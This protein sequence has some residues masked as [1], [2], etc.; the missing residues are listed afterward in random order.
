MENLKRKIIS[1]ICTGEKMNEDS[2]FRYLNI[3]FDEDKKDVRIVLSD[4]L[5]D[6]ILIEYEDAFHLSESN[7][8]IVGTFKGNDKGF[9]FVERIDRKEDD[10]YVYHM[11]V[12]GA[13]DGDLVHC[14]ITRKKQN[15]K[16]AEVKVLKILEGGRSKY[17]G[18][19]YDN[20]ENGFVQLDNRKIPEPIF[21]SARRRN[22]AQDEDKVFIEIVTR[23]RKAKAPSGEVVEI[24]GN[25]DS[26][27]MD[28]TTIARMKG[29]DIDFAPETLAEADEI[30]ESIQASELVHRKDLRDEMIFTIDGA[31][32]K[33]LDDAVSVKLLANGNYK[34]GVHIADVAH[35]V[36]EGSS[37]DEDALGRATSVYLVDRVIP[38]L[39]TKLSNGVCSL[40]PHVDRL[41]LSCEMEVNREGRVVS[42]EIFESVINSKERLTY[43]DVKKVVLRE[44]DALVSRY[45]HIL[46]I[47]DS[48]KEL[49]L[50]LMRKRELRG[51]IDF[52]FPESKVILDEENHPVDIKKYDR[53]IAT[54]IIEEFMILANET[55]SEH[56]T[57]LEVP[58]VYRIHEEPDAERMTKFKTFIQ[59]FGYSLD[60]EDPTPADLQ[61][62]L[63]QLSGQ[64]EEFAVQQVMLRSLRKALYSPKNAGHFG[65]A[66]EYYSHFTSPIRR[67]PDLQI[68][69]IIKEQLRGK[70]SE[71][72]I[73]ELA[74]IVTTSSNHSSKQELLAQEAERE[75]VLLK[76][77]EYMSKYIGE[78]FEGTVSG[79]TEYGVYVQL[80]NTVEGLIHVSNLKDDYYSYDELTFSLVGERTARRFSLGDKVTVK[81]QHVNVPKREIDFVPVSVE[82][83][84]EEEDPVL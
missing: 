13:L 38:M 36:T 64:N 82:S 43:D 63:T 60:S 23:S 83:T 56:F 11:N 48:A 49:A 59:L 25:K 75:S 22:G 42:H 31:D 71:R 34:L 33:D 69:R 21:V 53:N 57:K 9:G 32:S 44:D 2:L 47:L 70:L 30:P 15:N 4:L 7:D 79:I 61:R 5:S 66:S 29:I 39:P 81:L 72:R 26:V 80:P 37:L 6:G 74:D 78:E 28:I 65:L 3:F 24:L 10:F 77:A 51:A 19:F 20:G 35:Y 27:G 40:N 68:H 18:T 52:D 76:K 55:V 8:F 41:T 54:R 62:I 58:F 12:N 45:E 50:I 84:V 16:K 67:Y 17:I 1:L 14:K 46:D 73:E